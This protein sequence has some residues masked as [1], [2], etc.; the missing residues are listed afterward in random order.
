[1]NN[2]RQTV[3]A[4]ID[5]STYSKAVVDYAAWISQYVGAPLKLLHNIEHNQAPALNLSGNLG[6]GER[7]ELLEELIQLEA[8]RSKILREQG[9]LMLESAREQ[10]VADGL[11]NPE[12]L[13]QHGSLADSLIEM[14]DEIRVLVLGIR[15][16]AHEHQATA[17]GAQLEQVIRAMHRPVLVVNRDFQMPQRLMIAYDDSEAARKG[18]DM[19]AQSPLFRHLECHL[20]HVGNNSSKDQEILNKGMAV[21]EAAGLKVQGENL[22]GDTEEALLNY[23]K[24]HQVDLIVMGAFGHSRLRELLFGSMTLSMLSHAR[25]PLLLLR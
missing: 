4:C 14:E 6:L 16:E 8:R 7:E 20:V 15:G 22:I 17:I 3:L 19:V 21:L 18:L 24:T 5:G 13:Q 25:I 12:T 1:M 10:L 23:Q 2:N 9:K 11:Q